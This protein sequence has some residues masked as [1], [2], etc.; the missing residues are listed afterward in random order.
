MVVK[1]KTNRLRVLQS[2]KV[3]VCEQVQLAKDILGDDDATELEREI[4][5]YFLNLV[6]ERRA[7]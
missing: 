2:P 1:L 6:N 3:P 5:E 4:A 7:A